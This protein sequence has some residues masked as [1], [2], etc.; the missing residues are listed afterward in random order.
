MSVKREWL[1]HCKSPAEFERDA[2]EAKASV[3][4]VPMDKVVHRLADRP[5]GHM[6]ARWQEF[7]N[8][9]Q[10]ADELWSFKTPEEMVVNKIGAIGYAILREG[11]IVDTLTMVR[12]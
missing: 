7:V 8:R 6:T 2:L 5:F 1:I 4:N 11:E 3:F 10:P 12:T 9:M